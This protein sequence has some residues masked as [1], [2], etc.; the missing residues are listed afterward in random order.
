[1]VIGRKPIH[2]GLRTS[3]SARRSSIPEDSPPASPI[4][5][6][7]FTESINSIHSP[8]HLTGG[9][10][11]GISLIS[12]NLVSLQLHGEIVASQFRFKADLQ[13]NI[14]LRFNDASEIWK[15]LLARFHITNLPRSYQLS[16][17]IWSL[18]QGSTDLATY[19][20][21]LKTLWD[22]ADCVTTCGN[23]D[24]CKSTSK[25]Y[26][27]DK[28]IKFLAGLHDS[29]GVIRTQIIMKKHIP[30][31]SEVYNLLDQDHSQRT[32]NPVPNAS[33]FHVTVSD[34]AQFHFLIGKMSLLSIY[35]PS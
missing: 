29:Y 22:G 32:F 31:L 30:E 20:T 15:D 10:N 9:D 1:M 4:V 25:K 18:Q 12:E 14:I 16:Q 35:S 27:H 33:A 17:Q 13:E 3:A 34:P 28:V 7:L 23:C 6:D 11:P 24:C 8:F 21:K 5:P 26:D 19:Y 2:C